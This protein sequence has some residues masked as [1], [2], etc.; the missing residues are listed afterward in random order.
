MSEESAHPMLTMEEVVP[1]AA[2]EWLLDHFHQQMIEPR[3]LSQGGIAQI[4]SIHATDASRRATLNSLAGG[5]PDDGPIDRTGHHTLD[6]LISSLHAELRQ[7]R[8][9]P[10]GG[11]L[12][13]LLHAECV[14]A[15]EQLKFP[16]M[17]S[18]PGQ[19]W[20]RGKSR[21]LGNLSSALAEE[22]VSSDILPDLASYRKLIAKIGD[23]L[24]GM[25]P[26]LQLKSLVDSLESLPTSSIP[27]G[28]SRL[29]G[30]I[31]LDHS[32][33]M[34][35]L[36][37]RFIIS[38]A[39]FVPVHVLASG[40]SHRL[41]IHG[42]V[43]NDISALKSVSDLP[44]WLPIHHPLKPAEIVERIE[45]MENPVRLLVPRIERTIESIHALL[46]LLND[47]RSNANKSI[48]IIDPKADSNRQR[49]D[50]MLNSFGIK[51]PTPSIPL[52]E[53]PG[54]HWLN[55][56]A[57]L[58]HSEDA[59]SLSQLR[60]LAVQNTLVFSANWLGESQHPEIADIRPNPDV[61]VL[62][63]I[64]RSFHLLGGQGALFRWLHSLSRK[65]LANSYQ[66]AD[67]LGIKAESTQW[68]LLSL[69]TRLKPLL[70]ED[71]LQT[72]EM[73]KFRIGCHTGKE[74]PL[75]EASEGGDEWLAQFATML[76]WHEL[77]SRMDGLQNTTIAGLHKF[78][79]V[80]NNLRRTQKI[81]DQKP[82]MSGRDWVFEM[83]DLC[84]G[85]TLSG[86]KSGESSI[87][88]LTPR[89]ALGASAELVILTHLDTESW[90][91][92]P[93]TIPGL[94][95]TLR[96][97][98]GIL[99]PD[100][101]LREARHCWSHLIASGEEVIVI[102]T[103]DD[104]S[105]QPSTPLAEWTAS[106]D[107]H[108]KNTAILPSFLGGECVKGLYGDE[109]SRWG[110]TSIE[111]V[112][113]FPTARPS[114]VVTGDDGKFKVVVTGS[115]NRDK[116]QRSGLFIQESH[117]P[118]VEA[119]NPAAISIPMDR[120]LFEDRLSRQP[121]VGSKSNPY[122]SPSRLPDMVSYQDMKMVPG[123]RNVKVEKEPRDNPFW[124]V[125]GMKVGNQWAM[126]IDP[127][128][129]KPS[130]SGIVDHDVRTGFLNGPKRKTK[131]WSP[132]RLTQWLSC[133]RKGWLTTRLRAEG[134]EEEDDDI[135][136]RTRGLLIHEVWADFIAE[137]LN[138]EVG[139]ER[140]EFT[141]ISLKKSK[142]SI[143]KMRTRLLEIIDDK[144]PWLR[145]GDAIATVR[146]LD[147][148]G[149]DAESYIAT[150]EG[151]SDLQLA[152]RFNRLLQSELANSAACPIALE[153]PLAVS[154]KEQRVPISLAN[155][156]SN[157]NK[158]EDSTAQEI[159]LETSNQQG[160]IPAEQVPIEEG[161]ESDDGEDS[162]TTGGTVKDSA[163]SGNVLDERILPSI[164]IRGTIDRVEIIPHPKSGLMIDKD[165]LSE[166]CPLDIDEEIWSPKRLV[167]I[168]DLKSLDG[169][170]KKKRGER[171][172]KE[173]L[174]GIQLA[175]YARAWEI[176]HP[177][178][179]VIAVGI[180]EIGEESGHYLEVDPAYLEHVKSLNIGD[181]FCNTST[182]F[183]RKGEPIEKVKS[184]SFRAWL[185]HRIT[186]ALKI[187]KMSNEGCVIP[188]PSQMNCSYC[189]VK[190][191]CG[192]APIVGGDRKWN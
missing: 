27:F 160:Q 30:I 156:K 128:P 139:I 65:P 78:F 163:A 192:L 111:G 48:L 169:P 157:G 29:D 45:E 31:I 177:G 114:E 166:V 83:V 148:I 43:P 138:M 184:N 97:E 46:H 145:R 142:F 149:M 152:G 102:D 6:S 98:L 35:S 101:K 168:R 73:E 34:S 120:V 13:I 62:E 135:D 162:E 26:D 109:N 88:L 69:A 94:P 42:F 170:D 107:W 124:P 91:T 173:L 178:D 127:R 155:Q 167:I 95:D 89:E 37:Q 67:E 76:Q 28:L 9:L 5:T 175:L 8:L 80:H 153:W 52:K 55:A 104:E 108:P 187:G 179:R 86:T 10:R 174:S 117:H 119:I 75:P 79:E 93:S 154:K 12:S 33:S 25:H 81:L 47:D 188:T 118:E 77:T 63:N 130:S 56:L 140:E 125:I 144:A 21:D 176:T 70:S 82:P 66:N 11:V 7:P 171:H 191:V 18:I 41:G 17:H 172:K 15:A 50:S 74:L 131:V 68:W 84:D 60:A 122:M 71:D 44:D 180:S 115:H 4:M 49:W 59:W 161:L 14:K 136:V 23:D 105:S 96:S 53:S 99:P 57:T 164:S 64:A 137:F 85:T 159:E 58:P 123:G 182:L 165:G 72:L 189:R 106:M 186:A 158:E 40:G 129:L 16:L 20:G 61:D 36:R 147:L 51:L 103:V 87:R 2:P 151:E 141:P 32:P 100:D 113:H 39:R 183:R 146:R 132:S 90:S 133:P 190:S 143:E 150:L 126:S 92:S 1:G 185:R 22:A 54:V 38:L 116:V 24:S 110:L 181:V 3:A 112:G 121:R 134:E 19:R